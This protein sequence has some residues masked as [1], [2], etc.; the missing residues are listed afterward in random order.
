MM[1]DTSGIIAA[2]FPDQRH[3]AEC[4]EILRISRPP[5]IMASYVLAEVDYLITKFAGVETELK[6]LEEV[7]KRVY[8]VYDLT[9]T[10]VG[11]ASKIIEKYR[12]LNIGLADAATAFLA[13]RSNVYDILTLDHRHFRALKAGRKPFRIFPVI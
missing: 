4:A 5:R 1:L 9:N 13:E 3:H 10:E 6:F 8:E 11:R 12:D 2:L 7:G